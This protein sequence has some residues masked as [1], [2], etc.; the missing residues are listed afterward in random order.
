M[1][2]SALE[3]DGALVDACRACREILT[4]RAYADEVANDTV[5][6]AVVFFLLEGTDA[7][8]VGGRSLD[9]LVIEVEQ[10]GVH[11]RRDC[12]DHEVGLGAEFVAGDELRLGGQ[13]ARRDGVER[14][15][16]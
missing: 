14:P 2:E 4:V 9:I 6:V 1:A 5:A 16:L 8:V 3:H 7:V 15:A 10:A 13:L 11:A 12:A